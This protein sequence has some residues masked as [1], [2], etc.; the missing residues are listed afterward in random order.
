MLK[1]VNTYLLKAGFKWH[2]REG[3]LPL[4]FPD[5]TISKPNGEVLYAEGSEPKCNYCHK[6]YWF[7]RT[8][9]CV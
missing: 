7:H 3:K 9:T 4:S 5:L 1:N 8:C 6:Q 2:E